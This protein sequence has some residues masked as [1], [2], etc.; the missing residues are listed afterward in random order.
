LITL[1]LAMALPAEGQEVTAAING[2]I[3]DPSGAPIAGATVTATD[4]ARG[5][6]YTAETNSEGAYYLT[7]VQIGT[8][9]VKVEAKGFRTAVHSPFELVLN[10]VARIDLQMTV[11]AMSQTV[12]VSGATPLLQTETTDIGTHIDHVVT[13]NIPLIT[14]NYN[15]L[16]LLTPGAVATNPGAYVSGQNTFQV[17]RPYINGNREQTNNYIL[18]GIDNNQSDNNEVAYSPSVDAIQEF[19]LI[20]DTPSA[21]FGNFLGGIVNTTIKSGTNSY[22]GDAFEFFRNDALNANEWSNNLTG[23][24]KPAL[25]YNRF[26]GTFGGPIIKRKLFFFVDYLGQRADTPSTQSVQ[27]M[28]ADERAGNFGALCPAG[29]SAAGICTSTS[30]A[31]TQLYMPQSGVSPASRTPIPFNNLTA[32]GLTLSPAAMAI[33]NSPLY[34]LANSSGNRLQYSQRILNNADQGDVKIDWTPS[35]KDRIFGRYS[36]QSVRNPTTASFVFAPSGITDFEY[37]LKNGVIGWTRT[38]NSTTVNDFRAGFSYFPVSQGFTNP[39]G[40]NLPQTFGIP[41]SPS[42]FLPSIQG[43][44]GGVTNL[45]NPLSAFN[46]FAD[47]V[48]QIGD[49]IVKTHGNHEFR[50]GLQFKNYRDNF[51]YPGNEGLAGFFNFNGQYTGNGGSSPGSG[52]ADFML[53]LP[54]NLGIGEG[55]GNRHVRNSLWS[56]YGQD[57]WR[58]RQNLTLN[59]GLRWELNT[60]RF[61]ADGNAV[62]YELFGGNLITPQINNQGLGKALYKQYNGITNFQPRIGVAW[63]PEWGWA[64]NTVVRAAYG[65]TSFNESNGVNNLLT[66]NPPFEV[67]H[68]VTFAP[69]T[70]L[71]ASTLDQGFVGFPAG[72]TLAL[73]LVFAPVCFQGVNIH[74]FNVNIRPAVQQEWNLNIQKQFGNSTT[75]QIGYVGENDQHLSNIV[76]LQQ[77]QLNANG[78]ISPS[79]FLNPTLLSEVG[80]ARFSTSNGISNYNA[81]QLIFQQRLKY[82][83]Q[84]QLNYTWSKCLSDTPGFFGQFGDNVATEA[85]TIA[86]WAF[87]QNP[88]AQIGDY[89]RCPQ[90]NAN[91]FNGY[92]VYELPFGHGRRFGSD[93]NGFVNALV[94]GWRVSSGFIFHSGFAQT[95][96]AS[97]DTSGTGGFSTRADCVPGVPER[98]PMVFNPANGGVSFLNPAAVTTPATGTFG[99]CPVGAFNGPDYKSADLSLAKEFSITERQLLEFRVD[100]SNFTNT[101]IFNFGQEFSGQHTAGASNYG[102]IFTSQG[103]RSIQFALKYSF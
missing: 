6:I 3:T 90:N 43:L 48:I 15:K 31:N 37:P 60:P 22:H 65:V 47:T 34:P 44:F 94:G 71:P 55:V 19:N 41:G 95:I 8:F 92:V 49:S 27:V 7:S 97:S 75:I 73:A 100:M 56:A 10:Q 1:F 80:Q 76:M 35:E 53:G 46:T 32:A 38:L 93:V 39:T 16:T 40:Q 14:G 30:S 12:E 36:Q 25:R 52:L 51:L 42:T 82:G 50:I 63:Q 88:Y 2:T 84:A 18:D 28:T 5:T 98:V 69:T 87:P 20:T 62:N 17:G 89:G 54:N 101:P 96:F 68:N 21:E 11:G 99:N 86:G 85:Q 83:L 102:E 81:L 58:L 26:G 33:V 23:V 61:A 9:Q 45:G 66:A 29:F 59:L 103:A 78:T 4:T 91:L 72:C 64:K 24:P 77:K 13:E 67:A 57:N 70:A 74:A 79:P